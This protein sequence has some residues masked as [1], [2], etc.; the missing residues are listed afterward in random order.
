MR[1]RFDEAA[2][3]LKLTCP[4][5]TSR[6][7]ALAWALDQREWID[8]QLARAEPGEPF[9]P[10]AIIPIEGVDVR[11]VWREEWPRIPV[12][13]N[14]ALRCGGPAAGLPRRVEA[15]LKKRARDM[16]SCD[17]AEFAAAAGVTARSVTIGDAATRWGSCSSQGRIRMS[18]RLILAPPEVRRYVA[19]HEVA[20]LVH[21]N[22]GSEFKAFEARL[23]GPGISAAKA[24]LRRIGA[25]LRR[26]GRGR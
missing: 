26:I 23:Y 6:R 2:G 14:G 15:F 12:L 1:L 21:L 22:H 17:I 24:A 20:H 10:G 16:M 7:M 9:L 13:S 5:R 25:R 19:A 4:W 18:W 3:T 11:I 8:A